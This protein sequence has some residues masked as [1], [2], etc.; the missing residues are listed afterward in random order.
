MAT[1]GGNSFS[2]CSAIY[3]KGEMKSKYQI[4]LRMDC[5]PGLLSY[6]QGGSYDGAHRKERQGLDRDP[7][8]R[9]SEERDG[10]CER[11]GTGEGVSRLRRRS[12]CSGGS[13]LG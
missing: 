8:A 7:F 10:S 12:G 2:R 9:G 13:A 5:R 11:R 3:A 6:L 4:A 1:S